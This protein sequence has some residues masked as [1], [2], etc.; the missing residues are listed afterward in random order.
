MKLL[1]KLEDRFGR[2]AIPQLTLILII[3]Q[4]VVYAVG[5]QAVAHEGEGEAPAIVLNSLIETVRPT[6]RLGI[7]GLYVPSDPG[8]PDEARPG[9]RIVFGSAM[10]PK[11]ELSN[12]RLQR[13][14]AGATSTL[15]VRVVLRKAPASAE[16]PCR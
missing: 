7:P 5:Y 15:R 12:S 10:R 2:F 16:P 8:G 4:V 3:C 13:R 9:A 11:V 14:A 6:G 1:N